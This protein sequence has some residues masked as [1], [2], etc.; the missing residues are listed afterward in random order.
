MR[1]LSFRH[2]LQEQVVD[3]FVP[4]DTRVAGGAGTDSS[5]FGEDGK[6]F[7]SILLCTGAN[8]CGKVSSAI[9]FYPVVLPIL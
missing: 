5:F 1:Y 4:N 3:V 9:A 7:N 6:P 8:A 2:P